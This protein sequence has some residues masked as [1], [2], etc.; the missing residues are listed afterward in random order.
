MGLSLGCAAL[1]TLEKA[2]KSFAE[3]LPDGMRAVVVYV[4]SSTAVHMRRD[5]GAADAR[6][7]LRLGLGAR[8]RR[9]S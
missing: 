5:F 2:Y 1:P 9:V 8:Y 7:S 4:R 6:S 3:Y